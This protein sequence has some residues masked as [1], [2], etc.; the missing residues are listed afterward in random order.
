MDESL[1]DRLDA[2]IVGLR[3]S[4]PAVEAGAPWPL[5]TT[6]DH[7]D[8]ASWGPA[9]VLA[10]LSEMATYWTGEIERV[11]AGAPEPVPFGRMATD[12]VRLAVLERDRTLPPRELYDRTI[13][14]LERLGR[15]VGGLT[16]ADLARQG[17]HPRL[18]EMAV[19]EIAGRFVADHVA[20]HLDQLDATI[21]DAPAAT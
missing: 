16:A 4:R 11:L 6:I 15:R 5:G 8:E 1:V 10:H 3:A 19:A 18:G 20:E 13:S 12:P 14:A 9:E 2:A 21:A 7:S 17:L